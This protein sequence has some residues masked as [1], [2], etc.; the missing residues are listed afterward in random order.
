MDG[1]NVIYSAA[2][3]EEVSWLVSKWRGEAFGGEKGH[4][5]TSTGNSL[6]CVK[7]V[8]LSF[9]NSFFQSLI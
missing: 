8:S 9:C 2:A 7:S 1:W 6:S 5:I 3:Q 4:P